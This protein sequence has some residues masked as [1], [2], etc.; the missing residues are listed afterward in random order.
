MFSWVKC[1]LINVVD[2]RNESESNSED[3]IKED[4]SDSDSEDE[5]KESNTTINS[6]VED[7]FES[8]QNTHG[9]YVRAPSKVH[10]S[11][12]DDQVE[13]PWKVVRNKK[14]KKSK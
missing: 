8:Y 14:S 3:E 7:E 5:T 9:K 6:D 4:T 2:K 11:Y 13:E 12:T 1:S 10:K